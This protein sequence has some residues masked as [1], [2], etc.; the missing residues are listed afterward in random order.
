MLTVKVPVMLEQTAGEKRTNRAFTLVELLVV[1]GII[2]LLISI[3]LPALNKAR[4]AAKA[5]QCMSNLRQCGLA[6]QMYAN[7][8]RGLIPLYYS[9]DTGM[10]WGQTLATTNY[11]PESSSA[12]VCPAVD[13]GKFGVGVPPGFEYRVTYGMGTY[14]L[15]AGVPSGYNAPDHDICL[16][17]SSDYTATLERPYIS[18][19]KIKRASETWLLA[20]S[21]YRAFP[22][23]LPQYYFIHNA[24]S[25][26]CVHL[27]HA[28]QQAN[29]LRADGSVQLM[30]GD[31]FDRG[32]FPSVFYTTNDLALA[33]RFGVWFQ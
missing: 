7:D 17:T 14:W 26:A 19:N 23:E 28:N 11:L 12:L 25:N 8:N 4:Q 31:D 10:S 16:E 32:S 6:L 27:R 20:D 21:I 3:L 22:V 2:A 13:P 9:G 15:R 33:G 24:D 5:T 18:Y 1:I 30:T 29:T